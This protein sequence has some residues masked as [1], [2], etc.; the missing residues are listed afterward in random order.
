M[1]HILGTV[2]LAQILVGARDTHTLVSE[3][4]HLLGCMEEQGLDTEDLDTDPPLDTIHSLMI[5]KYA[6]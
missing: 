1:T 3:A 5:S 6:K 4:S 2:F